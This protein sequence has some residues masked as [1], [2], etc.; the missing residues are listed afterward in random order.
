MDITYRSSFA[1]VI[2][3]MAIATGCASSTSRKSPPPAILTPN[4]TDAEI[5]E[6]ILKLTPVGTP[7]DVAKQALIDAG[8]RC[9]TESN[10]E[11]GE[12][13][14]SCGCSDERDVWVT[15][16]WDIRVQCVDGVVAGA[17]CKQ[18]GIGP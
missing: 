5:A 8:L 7:I 16:V 9:S 15:W 18:A 17:T 1:V 13:Y 10:A 14:L 11:T 3:A 2:V 4:G 6:R 12:T